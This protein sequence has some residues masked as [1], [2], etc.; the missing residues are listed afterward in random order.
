VTQ[1]RDYFLIAGASGERIRE[2]VKHLKVFRGLAHVFW[3]VLRSHSHQE[4]KTGVTSPF[5]AE[6]TEFT[7]WVRALPRLGWPMMDG[8]WTCPSLGKRERDG[9]WQR[10]LGA[11]GGSLAR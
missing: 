8:A 6:D 11:E 10:D 1:D 7:R 2:N 3:L 9:G 5:R 4:A